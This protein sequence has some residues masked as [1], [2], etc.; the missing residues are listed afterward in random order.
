MPCPF[1]WE[2]RTLKSVPRKPQAVRISFFLFFCPNCKTDRPV[3]HEWE[4]KWGAWIR[5]QS[6][7]C[8]RTCSNGLSVGGER[9]RERDCKRA[10]LSRIMGTPRPRSARMGTTQLAYRG[11]AIWKNWVAFCSKPRIFQVVV[12]TRVTCNPHQTIRT[13][14][15]ER[16]FWALSA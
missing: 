6:E 4:E 9:E 14:T 11:F 3:T 2:Q 10:I 8:E 5:A 12:C 1:K 16:K 7:M 13:S 15:R